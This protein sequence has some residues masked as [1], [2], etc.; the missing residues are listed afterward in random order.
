MKRS[1]SI[2]RQDFCGS[3][4]NVWH[5][6][7]CSP[8]FSRSPPSCS[9]GP[10]PAPLEKNSPS[11]LHSLWSTQSLPVLPFCGSGKCWTCPGGA[12]SEQGHTFLSA[13]WFAWGTVSPQVLNSVSWNMIGKI[14]LGF[15]TVSQ[16]VTIL[17]E[18]NRFH[19]F[20]CIACCYFWELLKI[21]SC[22]H[23]PL[24]F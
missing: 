16:R 18:S 24:L 14:S 11:D 17:W 20:F 8:S 4:T 22:Q 19:V 15:V 1:L 12:V 21:C 2:E 10:F 7:A 6:W 9:F 5:I 13:A 23:L 3:H